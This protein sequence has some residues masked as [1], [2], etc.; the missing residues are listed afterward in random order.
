MRE[1]HTKERQRQD[2][3]KL[4]SAK[5]NELIAKLVGHVD[6]LLSSYMNVAA[7]YRLVAPMLYDRKTTEHFGKGARGP[8]FTA[9]RYALYRHIVQECWKLA[10]DTDKR[11]PSLVGIMRGLQQPGV[12]E[13][14]RGRYSRLRI[15]I[16]ESVDADTRRILER[17]EEAEDS[18]R[19]KEFDSKWKLIEEQWATFNAAPFREGIATLRDKVTAHTE[20][21]LVDG[22]Y[23]RADLAGVVKF[24]DE[25]LFLE[26]IK[27]I[28]INLNLIVRQAGFDWVDFDERITRSAS[29]YWTIEQT[30][31]Q[32]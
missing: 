29:A 27:D 13:A 28:I 23:E 14:L 31:Q 20:L 12:K 22:L 30:P 18:D 8:G 24:G 15:P 6:Q 1:I 5:T 7:E 16:D 2:G 4:T 9:I 11:T 10:C 3:S 32:E 19:E 26:G 21:R 25:R 17:M